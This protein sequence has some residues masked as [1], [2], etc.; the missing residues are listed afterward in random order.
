MVG[1]TNV[2]IGGGGGSAFL[3]YLQIAT[4]PNA[5][6]TAVNLAGD[7]FSGTAD[8]AGSLV[9]NITEPGTYTVTE[10]DGEV[11][12]I[13]IADNGGIYSITLHAFD[14]NFIVS[15][16]VVVD[17]GMTSVG[18]SYEGKFAV[19]PTITTS[20]I[21]SETAILQQQP[22]NGG[23]GIYRTSSRFYKGNYSSI[24]IRYIA[25]HSSSAVTY[26]K[27]YVVAIDEDNVM[28]IIGT[29]NDSSSYTISS[30]SLSGLDSNSKY[31]FGILTVDQRNVAT[32]EFK[33]I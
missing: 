29:M 2:S 22:S 20:T 10:T 19:A 30:F 12:S 21:V 9:L 5:V 3:A 14:G 31:Y 13:I 17:G 25:T 1:R 15:G 26:Y 32:T 8:S 18:Y 16:V 4:D 33:L 11:R 28:T 23:S 6:I 27:T 7:T 24:R